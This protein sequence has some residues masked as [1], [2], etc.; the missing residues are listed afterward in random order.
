MLGL[1]WAIPCSWSLGLASRAANATAGAPCPPA[2]NSTAGA[3]E[4]LLPGSRVVVP[5]L[6][7]LVLAAGAA[8][9]TLVALV[10]LRRRR[11]RALDGTAL[12]LLNLSAADVLQLACLP[13]TAA[14]VAS[15]RWA[16]GA[17]MCRLVSS[18]NTAGSAASALTLAALAVH[19]YLVLVAGVPGKGGGHHRGLAALALPAIWLP[20]LGLAA[21]QF[22]YRRLRPEPVASCLAFLAG[23]GVTAY[24]AALFLAGFAGPLL[25]VTCM[26]GLILLRLRGGAGA[27]RPGRHHARLARMTVALVLSFAACW[28]PSYVLMFLLADAADDRPGWW[29]G[30][31][32]GE[33]VSR[34]AAGGPFP[35]FARLLASCSTVANPLVYA[36]FSAQF[37]GELRR[38]ARPR[39]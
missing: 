37:R 35:V 19:R 34:P 14:A 20:A 7:A 3:G 11:A 16:F 36:A 21:P 6:D 33:G 29:E 32:E 23:A 9:H 15:A 2:G 39:R 18:A 28:L 1:E 38:L 27:T 30:E 4:R 24:S 31:G 5:L 12:L 17:F 26:Y 8:G 22:V 25:L 10:L 13:F